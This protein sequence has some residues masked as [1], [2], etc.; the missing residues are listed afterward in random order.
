MIVNQS[1]FF[2]GSLGKS[3]SSSCEL[4][5]TFFKRLWSGKENFARYSDSQLGPDKYRKKNFTGETTTCTHDALVAEL[6]GRTG[7]PG[8]SFSAKRCLKYYVNKG[9]HT[10]IDRDITSKSID[11]VIGS[12]G[13]MEYR[14]LSFL[15]TIVSQ[16]R[17]DAETN[18]L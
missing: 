5:A 6:V 3:W 2:I 17:T 8:G 16:Q 13:S 14:L 18:V 11:R 12:I 7:T 9:S 4:G 10:M 1:I 15:I